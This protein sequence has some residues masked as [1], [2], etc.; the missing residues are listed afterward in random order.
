MNRSLN[1]FRNKAWRSPPEIHPAR[2]RLEQ[3]NDRIHTS[4]RQRAKI[5]RVTELPK[6]T[7]DLLI[8]GATV[9]TMDADRRIIEDGSVAISGDQI[10]AVGRNSELH[11]LGEPRRTIDGT[12]MAVLPGLIDCHG[13]AGHGLVKSL[14]TGVDDGV[15][16]TQAVKQIYT[17]GA[18]E[19]FWGAEAALSGLDRLKAGVTT[20]VSLL[21]GGDD[22]HRVDDP[23]YAAMHCRS[24]EKLGTRSIVAVGP[25][26]PPYPHRFGTDEAGNIRSV[27]FEDEM[28]VAEEVISEWHG[29]ASGRI[30]IAVVS[31]VFLPDGERNGADMSTVRKMVL[32]VRE[33]C[34][35]HDLLLTQD[36]H[37]SGSLEFAAELGALGPRA[38]MSHCVDLTPGD[39]QALKDSGTS[40]AH[41]PS[42]IRSI[43]GRCPAPELMDLG[44]IVAISS[45]GAAPD[46][47]YDMFRHMA[48]CMHYHRR[49][50][51]DPTVLPAETA[52]AMT[53]IDAARALGLGSELGSIEVGKRADLAMID[54]YKPHL[55]PMNMP[56]M[57]IAHY[58]NAADVDT[59]IVDG[60]ILMEGRRVLSVDEDSVLQDAERQAATII[61]RAGLSHLL[62]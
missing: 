15:M 20:G 10:V 1:L 56:V 44:V 30:S 35:R 12:R 57:R 40:V 41:N 24:V 42:A 6:A 13:H 39:M 22:V 49:H 11:G 7:V 55:V 37:A 60:K 53:T 14:G 5:R 45:D 38:V 19:G 58:A 8:E 59:V 9:I 31:P 29:E 62:T 36:G 28:R 52:L 32:A 27:S 61:D 23:A 25:G 4:N 2:R 17:M 50:F 18:S 51:R 33:L 16:W 3:R 21:G 54:L 34:D 47:G 48:Q 46:R 26:R 43:M